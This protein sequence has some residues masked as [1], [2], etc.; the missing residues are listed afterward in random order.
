MEDC[1]I[2][3]EAAEALGLLFLRLPLLVEA[4]LINNNQLFSTEGL[5]GLLQGIAEG[6]CLEKL[7]L[8]GCMV[9]PWGHEP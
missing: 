1:D 9:P 6:D 4:N 8:D 3:P 5:A 2:V 7:H